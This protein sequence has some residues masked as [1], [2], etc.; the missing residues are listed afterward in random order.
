MDN[1]TIAL[2]LILRHLG[3][4]N[5][6][7][8]EERMAV[9][10]A[11][12]LTQVVGVP[13]GYS[14]GWYL[15]GPYSPSLTKDYYALGSEAADELDATIKPKVKELLDKIKQLS[16][17]QIDGMKKPQKLE[18]LASLHYL[19]AYS[20]LTPSQVKKTI[21]EKKYHLSKHVDD[22]VRLLKNYSLV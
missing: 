3:T 20:K 6:D 21:E 14:Y 17:E 9:Q 8:V 4:E 15:K 18:L 10:K 5:I 13:L 12:Y 22:G 7:T 19:M 1:R 2:K 11:V 16:D